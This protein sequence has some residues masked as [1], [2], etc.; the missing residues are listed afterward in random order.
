MP[1]GCIRRTHLWRHWHA[2]VFYIVCDMDLEA[3]CGYCGISDELGSLPF[4]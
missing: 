4:G 1:F 3:R 2:I